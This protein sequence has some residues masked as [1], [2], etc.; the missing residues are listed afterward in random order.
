MVLNRSKLPQGMLQ[1]PDA[2]AVPVV[3]LP[4]PDAYR[5]AAGGEASTAEAGLSTARR[6]GRYAF[7][8]DS[9][10]GLPFSPSRPPSADSADSAA[11]SLSSAAWPAQ[12]PVR[13][14]ARAPTGSHRCKAG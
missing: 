8:D 3:P 4:E 12:L 14:P 10:P 13:Y 6:R 2:T 5:G 9:W 11:A 7:V 1:R